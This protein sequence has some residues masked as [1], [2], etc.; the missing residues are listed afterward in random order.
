MKKLER[1]N[2]ITL[3]LGGSIM[4]LSY[5]PQIIHIWQS[6]SSQGISLGFIS[7]VSLAL[8]TFSLNGYVVLKRTGDKGTL[9]SQLAN[10]IPALILIIMII[11][12][13]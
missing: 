12:F 13:R 9:I 11:I 1:I 2:N 4:A 6:K 3:K 5:F 10:L 8:M 7:M